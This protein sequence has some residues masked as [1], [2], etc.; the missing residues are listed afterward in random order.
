MSTNKEV[1]L[2]AIKQGIFVHQCGDNKKPLTKWKDTSTT[3]EAIVNQWWSQN[4]NALVGAVTGS[5]SGFFVLDI[6]IK[7]GENAFDKLNELEERFG[8]FPETT[9]VQTPSGGL[10]IYFKHDENMNIRNSASKLGS[11][12]IFRWPAYDGS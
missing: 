11:N 10:H 5:K 4:P 9:I 7:E 6:D 1:A 12:Y 2:G 3:D 8:K